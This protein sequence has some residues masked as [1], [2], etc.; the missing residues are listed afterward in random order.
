MV[1]GTGGAKSLAS[2]R[3]LLTVELK[4]DKKRQVIAALILRKT[5]RVTAPT[6]QTTPGV[7]KPD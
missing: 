2:I 3:S 6:I 4:Q 1:F 5:N 7:R